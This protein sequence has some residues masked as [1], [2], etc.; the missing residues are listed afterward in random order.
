MVAGTYVIC[1]LCMLGIIGKTNPPGSSFVGF[2]H[3][4]IRAPATLGKLGFL[5]AVP[6]FSLLPTA[7]VAYAFRYLYR[8]AQPSKRMTST[9][10]TLLFVA[11]IVAIINASLYRGD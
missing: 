4:V 2:G 6:F 8:N 3:G 10:F 5:V 9:N 1:F 7:V 11:L